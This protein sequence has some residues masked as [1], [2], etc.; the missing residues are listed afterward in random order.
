MTARE[1]FENRILIPDMI[2]D[3]DVPVSA[4][5]HILKGAAF[6]TSW[7]VTLFADADAR[8][9]GLEG[10]LQ[11]V[12]DQIDKEMSPYRID[13]DLTRFNL[14]PDWSFVALPETMM[15]VVRHAL[16]IADL[17][18]G[19]FDPALLSAVELWGFGAKSV[20]VDVPQAADIQT[21]QAQSHN[22]RDII[23][24]PDGLIKPEGVRLDL[25]A[26]AKG[27]AVDALMDVLKA[28]GSIR[29]ALVEVGGELKGWGVRADGL[30][31]WV[32]VETPTEAVRAR[33][34]VALCDMAVATSGERIRAFVHE[35]RVMSHTMDARTQSPTRSNIVSAT[36]FDPQGWRADA[37]ATALVVMDEARG[38]EFAKAH[39]LPCLLWV[40][41]GAGLRVCLSPRLE[42]WL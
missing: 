28:D 3:P 1:T 21:L 5:S 38:M 27:Y 10:R 2:A 15:R 11:A 6:A 18:E 17:S 20:V 25:C 26:I 24:Q 4:N 39:Q 32:E 42:G 12:L 40:R 31:W 14:A 35:G 22:W 29:S 9:E 41:E 19:A 34:L 7:Q 13:S 16:E 37:L 23:W 33:T 8:L 36:V 30:P